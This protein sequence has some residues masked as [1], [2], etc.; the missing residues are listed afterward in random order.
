M[1]PPSPLQ[2]FCGTLS[3][4]VYK[5]V[6]LNREPKSWVDNVFPDPGNKYDRV[7]HN[8]LAFHNVGNVLQ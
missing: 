8:E 6:E 4:D 2:I 7:W 5:L 3:C 1:K